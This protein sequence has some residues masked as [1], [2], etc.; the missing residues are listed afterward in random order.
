[1]KTAEEARK[2]ELVFGAT[3]ATNALGLAPIMFNRM[4][5]ANFKVLIG[6][7]GLAE[8]NLAVERGELDAM[9]LT[10]VNPEYLVFLN[11]LKAGERSDLIPIFTTS[12][13]RLPELPNVPSLSEFKAS[14][15]DRRFYD[16]VFSD[17]LIGRSLAFPP[18]V[19]AEYVEAFRKGFDAMIKDPEF[20]AATVGKDIPIDPMSGA[21]LSKL[22]AEIIR[23]VPPDKRAEL[24]ETYKDVQ[25]AFEKK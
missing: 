22:I 16:V 6:Y 7:P 23:S 20:Q 13:T 4:A 15:R 3:G 14:D 25:K 21:E 8:I 12:R 24:D 2:K 19:P 18:G 10:V 9:A 17:A 5:G 11:K 1:V